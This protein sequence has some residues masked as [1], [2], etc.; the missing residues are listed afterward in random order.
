MRDSGDYARTAAISL[1]EEDSR[2]VAYGERGRRGE[3][4]AVSSNN[5]GGK[6]L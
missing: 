2:R 3:K 1:R 4:M 6:K 5:P